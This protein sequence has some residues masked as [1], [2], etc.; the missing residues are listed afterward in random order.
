VVDE[1]A[2]IQAQEEKAIRILQRARN[3]QKNTHKGSQDS[4][5]ENSGYAECHA[6][7][8]FDSPQPAENNNDKIKGTDLLNF[9]K[10]VN[11]PA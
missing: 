2:E 4:E 3:L 5:S 11:Q 7:D 6:H 1:L 8:E 9:F 10:R